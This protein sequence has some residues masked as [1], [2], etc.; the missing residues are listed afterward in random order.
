MPYI[1]MECGT[2]T[3][4]QKSRL[5]KEL[6]ETAAGITHIPAEFF[7]ITIKELPDRNFGIG[8]RS[9]DR[10]KAEYAGKGTTAKE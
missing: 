9:I 10:I 7:S 5:I 1:S 3:D 4:E 6:T 2:L 8:G